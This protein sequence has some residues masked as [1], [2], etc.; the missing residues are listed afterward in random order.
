MSTLPVSGV[1]LQ[2]DA[3][4]APVEWVRSETFSDTRGIQETR[5]VL[6]L[7]RHRLAPEPG[8]TMFFPRIHHEGNAAFAAAGRTCQIAWVPL[9]M[10]RNTRQQEINF[11]PVPDASA[12]AGKIKLTATSTSGLPVDYFVLKGP[13]AIREGAFLPMEMPDGRKQP[14]EVTIGAYQV[15]NYQTDGGWKPTKTSFR[16]FRLSP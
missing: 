3:N 16:S 10:G 15:G 11:P 6:R 2:F 12:T 7:K 13:G 5:F 4:S 14:V 8:Y 9:D 1:T